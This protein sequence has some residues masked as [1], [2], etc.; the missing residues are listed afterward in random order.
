MEP[1]SNTFSTSTVSLQIDCTLFLY[2]TEHISDFKFLDLFL[3]ISINRNYL[4]RVYADI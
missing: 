3:K 2:L 4:H 1:F